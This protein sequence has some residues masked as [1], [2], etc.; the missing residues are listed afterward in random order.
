MALT[1]DAN[2]QAAASEAANEV[3]AKAEN[4]GDPPHHG[5]VL[6]IEQTSD[7]L[8]R[9]L[10]WSVEPLLNVERTGSTSACIAGFGAGRDRFLACY[11]GAWTFCHGV[12]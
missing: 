9:N 12:V 2:P 8:G 3:G 4:L 5:E 1:L 11:V 7:E 10:R 6:R